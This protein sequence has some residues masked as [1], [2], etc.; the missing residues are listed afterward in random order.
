MKKARYAIFSF[1]ILSSFALFTNS[2]VLIVPPAKAQLKTEVVPERSAGEVW[3]NTTFS[4]NMVLQRNKQVKIF[5]YGGSVGD[6]VS[7]TFNDQT[8]AG[9]V[10]EGG[11]A[12]YLDPMRENKV[13]QDL[14]IT[15]K[16]QEITFSNVVVGDVLLC[17]GQS[18]M[19]FKLEYF[20]AKRPSMQSEYMSLSNYQNI[21]VY[22]ASAVYL[23]KSTPTIYSETLGREW[24]VLANNYEAIRKTSAYA[25]AAASNYSSV[26]GDEVPVGLLIAAIGGTYIEEWLDSASVAQVNSYAGNRNCRFYNAYIHNLAGYTVN[27]LLWYQGENN[28]EPRMVSDYKVAFALFLNLYRTIFSDADLP[29]I[30][31]QL[32]QYNSWTEIS[33]M[34]EAQWQ[35]MTMFS[36]VYTIPGAD[37]GDLNQYDDIHP[38]DKWLL[39]QRVAGTLAFAN[40]MPP[41]SMLNQ[42]IPYGIACEIIS[43]TYEKQG[44][45]KVITL[46][47]T[48]ENDVWHAADDITGFEVYSNYR[49]KEAGA[50]VIDGKIK[51]FTTL[52][53]ITKV[54]YNWYNGYLN[55]GSM[56]YVKMG[57]PVY[58]YDE[59]NL[60]LVISSGVEVIEEEALPPNSED[61]GPISLPTTSSEPPVVENNDGNALKVVAIVG[62]GVLSAG[63]VAGI[64]IF[65]IKRRKV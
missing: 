4:N 39:G 46:V 15:Y 56:N 11:W 9:V 6:V 20:V 8:K 28:S 5:G 45:Y 18:N 53:D 33:Y 1:L 52:D 55:S 25:L 63:L 3:V 13:G 2:K 60:P 30:V 19:E 50:R 41:S 62:G 21:R 17:S 24:K 51:V 32:S 40:D 10:A 31:Q 42:N 38:T 48:N 27:S 14:K 58:V 29:V 26:V 34:R 37:T 57:E 44:E 23:E 35:F 65:F 22:D 43:T 47:T 54:R 49:W 59:R 64:I 7:V 16:T 12:V 61:T 36:E